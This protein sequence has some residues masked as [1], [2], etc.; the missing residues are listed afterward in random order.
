M[1][2]ASPQF[3]VDERNRKLMRSLYQYAWKMTTCPF[4]VNKGILL[5]GDIGVGKSTLLKGLRIY[6]NQI[7]QLCYNY[8]NNALGF[9]FVSAPE[10]SLRY[11][12][13]GMNAIQKYASMPNLAIDEVGREPLDAKHYGT[14][15]NVIQLI[16]QLRY[17]KRC[18]GVT[19]LT[20][21]L[22]PNTQFGI[23]GHYIVDRVKEMFNVIEIRGESRRK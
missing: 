20:T 10:L 21:N 5:Y 13:A 23:Y 14:E 9:V 19:H 15:T 18:N 4:D 12:N 11:T 22:D 2:Q 16:L 7:N 3:M 1:R 17:E 6:E 8:G